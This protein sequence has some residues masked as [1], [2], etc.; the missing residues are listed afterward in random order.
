M[1]CLVMYSK[2][3]KKENNLL[4][5]LYSGQPNIEEYSLISGIDTRQWSP[6]YSGIQFDISYL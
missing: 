6:E 5:V 3:I 4:S 1:W 2:Q